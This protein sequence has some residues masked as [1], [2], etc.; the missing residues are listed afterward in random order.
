MSAGE[1]GSTGRADLGPCAM[2]VLIVPDDGV[3]LGVDLVVVGEHASLLGGRWALGGL[4]G[5]EWLW[6]GI[7]GLLPGLE[8]MLPPSRDWRS[9]VE[10]VVHLEAS[11][12]R[13]EGHDCVCGVVS[14]SFYTFSRGARNERQRHAK[15]LRGT[16]VDYGQCSRLWEG[17]GC[18]VVHAAGVAREKT[19]PYAKRDAPCVAVSSGSRSDCRESGTVEMGRGDRYTW[20]HVMVLRTHSAPSSSQPLARPSRQH[21]LRTYSQS[22]CKMYAPSLSPCSSELTSV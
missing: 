8:S 20:P 9:A 11:K 10:A 19:R 18:I 17:S 1:K 21:G 22:S 4:W 7:A 14:E 16:F 13:A 6:L 2:Q 3:L 5:R 12:G 15:Q